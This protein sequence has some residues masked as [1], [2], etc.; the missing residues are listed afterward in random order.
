V[1]ASSELA[2]TTAGVVVL[3]AFLGVPFAACLSLELPLAV[4]LALIVHHTAMGLFLASLL[5]CHL[6]SLLEGSMISLGSGMGCGFFGS[7]FLSSGNSFTEFFF[8]K[9]GLDRY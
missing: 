3:F 4:L 5:G 8:G 1:H 9:F 2:A 7:K 6:L